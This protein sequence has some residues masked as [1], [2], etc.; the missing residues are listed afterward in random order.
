MLFVAPF[1]VNRTGAKN[2]LLLAAAIMIFR[3]TGSGLVEGPVAISAMKMLHSLELPILAV[4]IFRYIAAH[5]EARLASTLYLVGV[6]FGH[7]L[8]LAV[9]SPIV[10]KSYDLIGFPHTYLLIA[11]GAA[12]FWTVSLFALSPTPAAANNADPRSRPPSPTP[13]WPRSTD[14]CPKPSSPA[15]IPREPLKPRDALKAARRTAPPWTPSWP[16]CS[17]ASTPIWRCSPTPSPR[18]PASAGSIP[19][20][21]MSNGPTV[22]GPACC[23]WPTRS[24]ARRAI[25]RPPSGRCKASRTASIAGSTW[26]TT[27]WASSI[28][29]PA[30]RPTS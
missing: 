17:R 4:S 29:C 14:P 19:P 12:L 26:I 2:G 7:S 3:I 27:T 21:A 23:G 15:P 9:L 6:S 5:F 24:A 13:I 28:R 16:P 10:G 1:I 11:L 8:G 20:W 18:R 25:G 30:W 22:S